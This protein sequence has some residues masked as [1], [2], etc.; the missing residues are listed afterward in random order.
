MRVVL[1]T[2]LRG[3]CLRLFCLFGLLRVVLG[4]HAQIRL[5]MAGFIV[6]LAS[7]TLVESRVYSEQRFQ[8]QCEP[9]LDKL[10]GPSSWVGRV[11]LL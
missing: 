10:V 9:G 1:A 5:S 3:V 8:L 6:W 7:L 11:I 4:K 2:P